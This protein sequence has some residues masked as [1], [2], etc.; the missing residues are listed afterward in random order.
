[1]PAMVTPFDDEGELD[2]GSCAALVEG[3]VEAGVSGIAALGST[4]E[5]SHL[6]AEERRRLA[7]VLPAMVGG[8]VPLLIGVG[9]SGTREATSLARHASGAGADAVV[10]VSPFYWRVGEEALFGHF[11]SVAEASEV[12][13]VV[14]NFP[15]LTGIDISP[16]LVGRMARECPNVTGIKDT[17]SQYMHTVRVLWEVKP[18]RPDFAVLAGI[19]DQIL[20]ALLAGADGAI[21]GLSNVTPQLFVELVASA[22]KGDLEGAAELHRRVLSLM[23]LADL[24]DPPIGAFKAAMSA[25]DFPLS[26]TVRGPALPLPARLEEDMRRVLAECELL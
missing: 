20:P 4:G 2:L 13:V 16:E 26:P 19:E 18:A 1:M 5:F 7:E 17:T 8:R 10:C 6:T 21:S 24:S 9:A 11:A 23:R 14:Y 22:K 25:L 12:P 3:F 15:A